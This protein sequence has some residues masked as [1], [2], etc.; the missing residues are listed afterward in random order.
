[1]TKAGKLYHPAV[2]QWGADHGG[3]VLEE[4]VAEW[5]G[6]VVDFNHDH[7]RR[8]HLVDLAPD[9]PLEATE[10]KYGKV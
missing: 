10:I 7:L 1:V 2:Q 5:I 4:F 6:R 9:K 8:L 3:H